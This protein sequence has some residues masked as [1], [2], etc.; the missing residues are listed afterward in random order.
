MIH[1]KIKIA[2]IFKKCFVNIVKNL[3]ILTGKESP[4][5]TENYQSKVEIALKKYNNYPGMNAIT[6]QMKILGQFTLIFNFISHDD[7]A[8]ELN[9][10]KNKKK[11]SQKT[12]IPIKIVKK[13]Q[14]P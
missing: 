5:F 8:K 6:E 2:K 12:D 13:M 10:L 7:T 14:I 9:K 4:A 1:N 11:A 3:G